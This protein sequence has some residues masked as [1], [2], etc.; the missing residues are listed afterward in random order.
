MIR[1]H[2]NSIPTAFKTKTLRVL[3]IVFVAENS[4]CLIQIDGVLFKVKNILQW[5]IS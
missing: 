3:S 4:I 2:I 5:K 1:K